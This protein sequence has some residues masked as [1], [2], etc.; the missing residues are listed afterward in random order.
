MTKE[1]LAYELRKQYEEAKV[2]EAAMQVHLFGIEHGKEI[3]ESRYL[4]SDI[5]DLSGIGKGYTAELSKGIK[6]SD[7]VIIKGENSHE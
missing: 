6:L 1:E 5:V 4:A 7:K 2:N 3:K